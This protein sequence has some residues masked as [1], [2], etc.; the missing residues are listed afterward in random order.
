VL[1]FPSPSHN[2]KLHA[3]QVKSQLSG[4]SAARQTFCMFITMG[5]ATLLRLSLMLSAIGHCCCG[6]S[7]WLSLR[8]P[9]GRM[10]L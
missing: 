2:G 7:A 3:A 9:V 4:R 5:Y 6:G 1:N 8:C 10:L